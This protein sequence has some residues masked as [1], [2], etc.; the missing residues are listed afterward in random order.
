[1]FNFILQLRVKAHDNGRPIKYTEATVTITV[2][3]NEF[4]PQWVN[5]PYK[6][7]I[8]EDITNLTGIYT[9]SAT[10]NDLQE[11]IIYEA[12]GIDPAQRYFTVGRKNGFILVIN[13][14]KKDQG[15]V[16]TV[17]ILK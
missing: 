14:L 11:A 2:H 13:N 17:S 4:M 8:N 5:I 15:L 3:R 1:M 9:V 7:T 16:Y 6:Q 12:V 10:D